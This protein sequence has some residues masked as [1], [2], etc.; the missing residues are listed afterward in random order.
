MNDVDAAPVGVAVDEVGVEP[1]VE[2]ESVVP[3]AAL[4]AASVAEVTIS[5][6][7]S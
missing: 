2:V 7:G 3:A 1:I 4:A 6:F 5:P